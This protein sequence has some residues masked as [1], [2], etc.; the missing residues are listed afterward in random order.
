MMFMTAGD[1]A[2]GDW[3]LCPACESGGRDRP[4]WQCGYAGP[5][6]KSSILHLTQA[7]VFP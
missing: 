6:F 7:Q 4:C 5:G 2:V 1:D 3:G